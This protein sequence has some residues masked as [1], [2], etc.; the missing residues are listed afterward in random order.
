LRIKANATIDGAKVRIIVDT[1][2]GDAV[3][4]EI[5]EL[6]LPVL[7]D[8]PSPHLRAYPRETV[9]AEKFQAMVAQPRQQSHEGLLRHLGAFARLAGC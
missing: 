2:F 3:E 7:L 1:G 9:V 6:D 8:Q 4:P 5:K